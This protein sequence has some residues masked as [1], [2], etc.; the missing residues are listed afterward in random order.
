[1]LSKRIKA[2]AIDYLIMCLLALLF[3]PFTDDIFLVIMVIYTLA[4]NKDFLNGK[5]IGKRVM[6][7]QVQDLNVQ[8]AGEWMCALRNFIFII[9]F[10]MFI[11]LF[12]PGRRMGD[13]LAGTKVEQE[14]EFT[15]S[16]IHS[17]LKQFRINKNLILGL[18][19]ALVNVYCLVWVLGEL[20]HHMVSFI[21]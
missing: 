17:E 19:F 3:Y 20:M 9:P 16:T 1:M 6:K 14:E 10:E 2:V 7:I 15:L 18:L 4:M 8:V 11:V 13:Y 12:S 5:S 21:H